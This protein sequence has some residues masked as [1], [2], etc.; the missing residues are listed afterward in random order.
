MTNIQSQSDIIKELDKDEYFYSLKKRI[1]L[2]A[3][4]GF[5]LNI[6]SLLNKIDS[7]EIKTVL[8]N[9]EFIEDDGQILTPLAVAC[10]CGREKVVE[11]LLANY[12]IDL[13]KRCTVKFDGHMVHGG[14]ALWIAAGSGH[15]NIVKMLVKHGANVN[16]CTDTNSTP[17]RAA[18]FDGRLDIVQYLVNHNADLN[19]PNI[20]NN[21]CLMI[22]SYRGHDDV[23][24]FLLKNGAQVNAQA[25]C[26]ATSLHY[27]SECGHLEICKL[28][29]E[30][31]AD[32]NL[33]N[34]YGMTAFIQAA[35]RTKEE[36]VKMFCSKENLLTKVQIIDCYELIGASFASD[37]DN[38]NLSKAYYYF[39]TAMMMRYED[40]DNVIKK[41]LKPPVP[42][43]ENWI[44]S[45]TLQELVA[46]QYNH[47]SLHMEAL[48]IRERVLGEH[49]P[50][51]AHPVVFRGAVSA[52]QGRFD[53]CIALWLHALEL[54]KKNN[55]TVQRD[56]LRFAQL[57]SQMIHVETELKF[58]NVL[59][60]LNATLNELDRNQKKIINPG[61]KDDIEIVIEEYETNIFTGLYLLTIATKLMKNR[62]VKVTSDNLK[63][64]YRMVYQMNHMNLKLRDGQTLIHLACN[65]ISPVDDFHTSDVCKFPCLDTVKLLLHCGTSVDSFDQD[66]NSPLHTLGATFP[67]FRNNATS[68]LVA[69]AE[70]IVRLFV[71]AGIHLDCVN[72]DGATASR[73]CSLQQLESFIKRY[74]I[75]NLSLKC[76]ASRV[77]AQHKINY[78]NLVPVHL[79]KFIQLHSADKL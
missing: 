65:G 25:N 23:V 39:H 14:S 19:L 56:L 70:E 54:R 3:K 13:D 48:T 44:E 42:A 8:V 57:F 24:E 4:D 1:F 31:G 73:I 71:K 58:F 64:L 68:E 2:H 36:V 62:R 52:D 29:I 34:E 27:A 18:C 51:V 79:E 11:I 9:Q 5:S 50:E 35:E 32:V 15:L 61:P 22:S 77:I 49:C 69:K 45:N 59:D 74:E 10:R 37:K 12:K 67:S 16:H 28:L 33:K 17:L 63:E 72:I 78:H 76:L 7:V 40:S 60:V 66:R 46:I 6:I 30:Y 53:R 26:Q 43:Y 21:T 20:Y 41:N 47:N 75:E 55:I 38:Y